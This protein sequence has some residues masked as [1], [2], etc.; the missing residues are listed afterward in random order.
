MEVASEEAASAK[1]K[2]CAAADGCYTCPRCNSR[3]CSVNCYRSAN[4]N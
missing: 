1:C 3:Y 4:V 2:F